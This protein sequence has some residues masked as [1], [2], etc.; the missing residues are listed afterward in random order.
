MFCVEFCQ[1]CSISPSSQKGAELSWSA[2]PL[3]DASAELKKL[4]TET[5]VQAYPNFDYKGFVLE[6]DVSVRGLG[7]V[8][9]QVQEDR[10]LHLVT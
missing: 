10:L 9:S 6:T 1:D 2:S 3:Q 8:L 5:Q 7:S 4:L